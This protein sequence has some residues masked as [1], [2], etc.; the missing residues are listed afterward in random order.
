MVFCDY[1]SCNN[2]KFI[3]FA[4]AIVLT[5]AKNFPFELDAF[6]P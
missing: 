5:L 2:I 1:A 4:L 3:T 6:F